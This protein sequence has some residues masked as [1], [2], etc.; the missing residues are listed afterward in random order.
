MDSEMREL[1]RCAEQGDARAKRQLY[2]YKRRAGTLTWD[3][4][5]KRFADIVTQ[6][7]GPSKSTSGGIRL[8]LD[9]FGGNPA[10]WYVELG[11]YD[12]GDWPRH[13]DL[14]YFNTEEEARNAVARKLEEAQAVV[15]AE[16][17]E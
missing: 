15:D 4:L 8:Y 16:E 7:E 5:S 9:A 14:G 13:L 11:T 1:Q 3:D 17:N 10:R 6:A 12:I 2:Q